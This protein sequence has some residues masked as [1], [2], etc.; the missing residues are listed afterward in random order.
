MWTALAGAAPS[1]S[2]A[3]SA[4]SRCA[5]ARADAA[6]AASSRRPSRRHGR[7]RRRPWTDSRSR[8]AAA[9]AAIASAKC[10]Q[11]RVAGLVR[12][13]R[14][15]D[16]RRR[17][18]GRSRCAGAALAPS[19]TRALDAVA[20]RAPPP[21]P[22]RV[23]VPAMRANRSRWRAHEMRRAC[24]RARRRTGSSARSPRSAAA[25]ASSAARPFGADVARSRFA[26]APM[27]R[28]R[29][30]RASVR[31]RGSSRA[32][33]QTAIAAHQRRGIVEQPHGLARPAPASPELPSAISTL[34]TKRSRPVRLTGV[35]AKRARKAASSSASEL[36][37]RR[38]R[39]TRRARAAS[40]RGRPA[41]NLF[42][43]QT[44][45]QSSQPKMRLPMRGAQL[46]RD[47]PLVLDRQVGDAAPRI[48]L[49]GRRE[50]VRRADV[51]AAPA[52]AAVVAL[53]RR[54]AAARRSVKIAPRNSQEPNSRETRMV[55]LPCQPS[56]AASASGFSITGAV[57]TNTF[58]S[59]PPR[60]ARQPASCLSLPLITS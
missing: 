39:E 56:P 35:P 29:S 41:A 8:R 46:G 1:A 60:A 11:H 42:Q 14:D 3:C 36:G 12:R 4:A 16:V 28:A 57:S 26:R 53:G 19:K 51:E 24:S 30:V 22:A 47:R 34:R 50:G 43:G 55:C 10:A 40:P 44:A 9:R 38:R 20:P 59:A 21:C 54:R 31:A 52:G 5:R 6:R 2:Q 49:V 7:H 15:E 17:R 45:R 18:R 33:A 58:T 25:L 32:S 13:D 48:E 37:E 23:T 27:P